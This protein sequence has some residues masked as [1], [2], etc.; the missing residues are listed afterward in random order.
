[1]VLGCGYDPPPPNPE[2]KPSPL[3]TPGWTETRRYSAN[4]ALIVEV[5]C[6]DRDRA[7]GI[8]QALVRPVEKVYA[9][10]LVYVRP[11]DRSWTRRVQW[12]PAGG[13]KL[14]DY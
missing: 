5:Q 9:E 2:I 13:F 14:L 7:L 3:A 1:M 4:R 10:V 11:P 12:T 6:E 8:G